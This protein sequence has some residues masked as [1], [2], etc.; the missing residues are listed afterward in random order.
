MY[1]THVLSLLRIIWREH[2]LVDTSLQGIVTYLLWKPV[3]NISKY[4]AIAQ[5]D[6]VD[7]T[8]SCVKTP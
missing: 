4:R 2:L 8:A 7:D 6:E 3:A 5:A 1:S